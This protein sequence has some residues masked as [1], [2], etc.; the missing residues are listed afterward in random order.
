MND[1]KKENET[2]KQII[3]KLVE[4]IH[5]IIQPMYKQHYYNF[6][7]LKYDIF[8]N[9]KMHIS[10]ANDPKQKNIF[11]KTN[12]QTLDATIENEISIIKKEIEYSLKYCNIYNFPESFFKEITNLSVEFAETCKKYSLIKKEV[13]KKK[14]PF[15]KHIVILPYVLVASFNLNIKLFYKLFMF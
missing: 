9:F 11:N 8:Y 13:N 5:D 12:E 3:D 10:I 2:L 1:I 7:I 4:M 14:K 6:I 15:Q